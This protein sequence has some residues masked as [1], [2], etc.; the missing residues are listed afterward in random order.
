MTGGSSNKVRLIVSEAETN[1]SAGGR[2][3]RARSDG[4]TDERRIFLASRGEGGTLFNISCH[5]CLPAGQSYRRMPVRLPS[6]T[7]G[8]TCRH[9]KTDKTRVSLSRS[10]QPNPISYEVVKTEIRIF[11]SAI[12]I[13]PRF[14]CSACGQMN[15]SSAVCLQCLLSCP[16]RTYIGQ[17]GEGRG[18]VRL[19]LRAIDMSATNV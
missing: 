4:R 10:G 15:V 5:S 2:R 3:A 12:F 13:A 14:G 19:C 17:T 16:G 18:A 9:R 11:R 7:G 8:R 6:P 1:H